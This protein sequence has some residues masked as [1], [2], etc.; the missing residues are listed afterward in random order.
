MT[1][2]YAVVV[3]RASG[4]NWS[5]YVPDVPGCVSTGATAEETLHHIR[6][7]LVFHLRGQL[8]D[9]LEAPEAT[10]VVGYAEVDVGTPLAAG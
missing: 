2:R 6:E 10:T 1:K 3:E 4:N 9:G 8:E 7:A 5:A